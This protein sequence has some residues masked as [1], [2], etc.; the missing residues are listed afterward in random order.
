MGVATRDEAVDLVRRGNAPRPWC[1]PRGSARP[2]GASCRSPPGSSRFDPSARPRRAVSRP[3]DAGG[4]GAA[5]EGAALGGPR[6]G[7]V[8]ADG[9][10]GGPPR[11]GQLLLLH[12]RPG[13]VWGIL[14]AA[15]AF[16]TS[17]VAERVRA[18]S[19]ASRCRRS[20]APDP[21]GRRSPASRPRRAS[22][23][24]SWSSPSRRS[25]CARRPSDPCARHRLRLDRV[26]R[27]HDAP[28]G[29]RED[30]GL[31][32]RHGLGRVP[33]DALFG[34]GWCPC[35]SCRLGWGPSAMRAPSSGRSSRS[36]AGS[37]AASPRRT[38]ARLRHPARH[39]V[40]GFAVGVKCFRWSDR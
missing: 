20:P 23:R 16:G 27:A 7:R 26:R 11:A 19:C 25:A 3:A 35:S 22:P 12:V 40:V 17:I 31:G 5:G 15:A 8:R 21:D 18:P 33:H 14:G 6:A 36:K 34:G 13:I 39:R 10:L 24:S 30:G 9:D 4:H 1:S 38:R 28:R 37:G 32:L 2:P 29:R